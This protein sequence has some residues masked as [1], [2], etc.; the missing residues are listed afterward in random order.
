MFKYIRIE[1]NVID[2]KAKFGHLTEVESKKDIKPFTPYLYID[3]EE[4]KIYYWDCYLNYDKEISFI[5]MSDNI[6]EL[7]DVYVVPR[8]Q[9]I[10][11]IDKFSKNAVEN[12]AKSKDKGIVYGA[13]WTDKGL[14]FVAKINENE[15]LV[16]I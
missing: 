5:A 6:E 12:Y 13:I 9:H 15:E 3:L 2:V 1:N 4:K 8:F 14:I 10:F 16:L 7:C 11:K